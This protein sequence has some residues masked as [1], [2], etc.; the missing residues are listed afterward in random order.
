MNAVAAARLRGAAR[1]C[2]D[3]MCSPLG[4]WQSMLPCWGM[5][6]GSHADA[7]TSWT[8]VLQGSPAHR[9]RRPEERR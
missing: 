9:P 1:W 7:D 2:M 4:F 3:C 6:G 8:P 5:D